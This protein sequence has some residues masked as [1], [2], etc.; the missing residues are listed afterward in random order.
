VFT[1]KVLSTQHLQ[2]WGKSS[3]EF[4]RLTRTPEEMI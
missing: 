4:A 2:L 1:E 3:H